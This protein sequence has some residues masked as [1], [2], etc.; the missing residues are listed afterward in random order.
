MTPWLSIVGIGE[1]GLDGLG[2]AARMLVDRAEVLVGGERHLAMV[3]SLGPYL[4]EAIT[5]YRRDINRVLARAVRQLFAIAVKEY[6]RT[7]RTHGVLDFSDVLL[8]TLDL[9]RT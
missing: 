7:L 8:R 6:E 3:Q 5:E 9:L 1:D 4:T 2:R